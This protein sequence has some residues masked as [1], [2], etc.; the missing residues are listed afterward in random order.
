MNLRDTG[1]L[2]AAGRGPRFTAI[3]DHLNEDPSLLLVVLLKLR[4]HVRYLD[5]RIR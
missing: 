1:D 5:Y 4:L 3:T 2:A